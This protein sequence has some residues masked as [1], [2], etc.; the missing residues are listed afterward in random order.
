MTPALA[1][2][3]LVGSL[4]LAV[5]ALTAALRERWIN[6]GQLALA[7]VIE[8]AILVQ[9][10][11]AAS[12]MIGGER[13]VEQATF[14]GYLLTVVLLLPAATVLAYMEQTRWGAVIMSVAGAVVAVLMLRL[15]QVWG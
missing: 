14:I 4:V 7:A 6:R 11:I 8:V 1:T 13:A 5:W 2:G 9:A 15:Q 3:I 12:R 10:V